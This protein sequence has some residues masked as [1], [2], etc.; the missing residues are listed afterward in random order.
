L[1]TQ[2]I[3][4]GTR[5]VTCLLRFGQLV[6]QL[7]DRGQLTCLLTLQLLAPL[8]DL[9]Q[10]I[11][12]ARLAPL[13]RLEFVLQLGELLGVHGARRKHRSIA[14]LTL[15]D[16]VDLGFELG[17]LPVKV[18]EGDLYSGE[19]VICLTVRGLRLLELLLRRQ[20]LAPVIDAT[21]LRVE[22]GQ[23]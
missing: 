3:D 2:L 20:I 11:L 18:L 8:H 22:L 4:L 5:C 14:L 15:P 7:I 1:V 10:R 6:L 16:R 23:L 21:P 9:E 17:H 19:T 13:Q 12:Q